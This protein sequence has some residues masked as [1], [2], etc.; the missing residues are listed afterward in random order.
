MAG[1]SREGYFAPRAQGREMGAPRARARAYWS[2]N[3]NR[4]FLR[5]A[6]ILS[7]GYWSVNCGN[8]SRAGARETVANSRCVRVSATESQAVG[9]L[10]PSCPQLH[11][12][13]PANPRN[14]KNGLPELRRHRPIASS[15]ADWSFV[16]WVT[17]V[18]L[19]FY[20]TG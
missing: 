20:A 2:A 9:A 13:K 19:S 16:H 11:R 3:V 4:D 8:A 10:L 1:C 17:A 6:G 12:Q 14:E 18:R 15:A 7:R 5:P